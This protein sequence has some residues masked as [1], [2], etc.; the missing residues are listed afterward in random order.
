[1]THTV[2]IL[3]SYV[4]GDRRAVVLDLNITSLDEDGFESWC[5]C[6]F[7]TGEPV[8]VST[9]G[10]Q[11]GVREIITWDNDERDQLQIT[12]ANGQT[13]GAGTDIGKVRLKAVYD[14]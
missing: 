1:M 7:A 9:K 5:P 2:N 14:R 4:V 8:E 3:D 13:A 6:D 12:K 11:T 10:R